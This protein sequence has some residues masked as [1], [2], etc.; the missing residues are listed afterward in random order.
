VAVIFGVVANLLWSSVLV[1]P[2]FLPEAN[3]LHLTIGRYVVYGLICCVV[4]TAYWRSYKSLI[5]CYARQ[6]IIFSLTGKLFYFFCLLYAV[7]LSGASS[8]GFILGLLPI[9]MVL[10]ARLVNRETTV[11]PILIPFILILAGLIFLGYARY[12]QS[13]EVNTSLSDYILGLCFSISALL[14]WTYY[15]IKNREFLAT[16]QNI[17]S[18]QW[19]NLVGFYSFILSLLI[20]FLLIQHEGFVYHKFLTGLSAIQLLIMLYLGIVVTQIGT[21]LW[22]ASSRRQSNRGMGLY[23]LIL[24]C[25]GYFYDVALGNCSISLT[26][27]LALLFVVTG[28]YCFAKEE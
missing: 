22:N 13:S 7:K 12:G 9:S 24:P 11:K 16:K 20:F 19:S 4:I 21:I 14:S 3:I 23:L 25:S 17:G 10:Y 2:Y 28:T 27:V 26:G 5:F 8:T 6:A 15:S 18:I 1:V